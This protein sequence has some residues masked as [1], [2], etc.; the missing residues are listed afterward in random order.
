GSERMRTCTVPIR[1]PRGGSGAVVGASTRSRCPA[2]APAVEVETAAFRVGAAG[3]APISMVEYIDEP[4][5]GVLTGVRIGGTGAA[6][7]ASTD[8]GAAL[9]SS[10]DGG[11][12]VGAGALPGSAAAAAGGAPA[13]RSATGSSSCIGRRD[14]VVSDAADPGDERLARTGGDGR[15]TLPGGA[16]VRGE[17]EDAVR[18]SSGATGVTGLA[19]ALGRAAG[20][21]AAGGAACGCSVRRD[22]AATRSCAGTRAA[23]TAPVI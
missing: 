2:A 4:G 14:G 20:P 7:C 22:G 9:S 11:A 3:G 19:S 5:T 15:P 17:G 21:G 12:M 10:T 6:L 16:S 13:P 8:G 1:T 23:P 18:S